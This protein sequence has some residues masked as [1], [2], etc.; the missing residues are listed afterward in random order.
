MVSESYTDKYYYRKPRIDYDLLNKYNSG[1]IC[2]SACLGG[3]Y[4]GCYWTHREEGEEAVLQ[5]MRKTTRRMVDI[6]GDRWYGELQWNN[7]PEQHELNKYVI[8]MHHEF[9]IPLVS[10]ADSHYPTPDA[11]KDR[12]LYKRLGLHC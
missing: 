1:V 8:Q 4:A 10:T 9:K 5:A 12:E 6:L 7:V 2:L 3:V 11:W